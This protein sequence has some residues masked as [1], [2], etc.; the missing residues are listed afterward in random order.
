MTI[1]A[2][3]QASKW[4]SAPQNVHIVHILR[5]S[6]TGAACRLAP[7]CYPPRQSRGALLKLPKLDLPKPKK[8]DLAALGVCAAGAAIVAA[9][10]MMVR[11]QPPGSSISSAATSL[12]VVAQI[13]LSLSALFLLGKTAK[14]GTIWGNLLA[15]AGLFLGM[16][17][18]LLAAALWAAA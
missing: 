3:N 5:C 1:F 9:N 18:V 13:A 11:N 15:V 16:S 10:L 7:L 12:F 14:E 4:S 17:G 2:V 8:W 6:V